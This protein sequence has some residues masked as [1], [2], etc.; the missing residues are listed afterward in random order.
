MLSGLGDAV[1]ALPVVNAL[2]RARPD[3]HITWVIEPLF[4]P[5]VAGHPAVDE[6]IAYDR[7]SGLRGLRE[8]RRRLK[9]RHFD[10]ALNLNYF[11]KSAWPTIFSGAPRRVG[12]DR[13]RTRDWPVWLT[14]NEHLAA[15][16]RAHTQDMFLEFL[17]HLEIEDRR[18]E[19]KISLT[20]RE[21]AAQAEFFAPVSGGPIVGVIPATANRKKDWFPERYAEVVNAIVRDFGFNAVLIGGPGARET[22]NARSISDLS[23]VKPLWGMGDGIRRLIWLVAGCDLIIA[24]DTGPVHIARALEVPVVGLYGHTNPWRVGPYRKYED[25]WIDTYTRPGRPA[26]AS[27]A[28]ARLGRMELITVPQVLEKVDLARRHYLTRLS[29][30]ER[31]V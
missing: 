13:A 26:N 21:R 3:C 20:E 25:L 2:K 17:E 4:E 27:D 11:L 28:D 7:S 10:L 18:V 8:L 29:P 23:K 16:P 5:L 19:W 14:A 1:H 24:P 9:G 12:Y 31:R 30:R 22:A 15:R 6:V